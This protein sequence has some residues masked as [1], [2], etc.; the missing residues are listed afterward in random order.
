MIEVT[1]LWVNFIEKQAMVIISSTDSQKQVWAS[2]L[3]GDFGFVQV[4]ALNKI[5]FN[6]NLIKSDL[7]DIFYQNIENHLEVGILFI[8]LGSRRRYRINGIIEQNIQ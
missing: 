6:K 5:V 2:V 1:G 4:P 3:I 8:E 7:N